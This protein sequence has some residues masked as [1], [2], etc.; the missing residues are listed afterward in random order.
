MTIVTSL[1][2]GIVHRVDA[3]VDDHSPRLD[4]SSAHHLCPPHSGH[5]DV[6]AADGLLQ[7]LG[8]GVS[9]GHGGIALHEQQRHGDAHDVGA[10]QN[11]GLLTLDGHSAAVQQLD[12]ALS[13]S[14]LFN[15]FLFSFLIQLRMEYLRSTR[16]VEVNI[17]E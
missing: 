17:V 15:S 3:H 6:C 10:T 16:H 9:D 12:T 5:Y 7:V 8:A 2:G 11:H 13:Q 1:V 14:I 4:P